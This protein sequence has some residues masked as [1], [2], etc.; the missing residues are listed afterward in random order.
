ML[1]LHISLLSL[2]S[3]IWSQDLN[4]TLPTSQTPFR[5]EVK[6]RGVCRM[7]I[8]SNIKQ[9]L[10]LVQLQKIKSHFTVP[11]ASLSTG[12]GGERNSCGG[13]ARS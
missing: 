6:M 10:W 11:E 5:T 3:E 1:T 9:F 7:S 13:V 4:L 2:L 8:M 12:R